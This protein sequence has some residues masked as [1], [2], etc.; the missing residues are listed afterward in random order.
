M[1][2]SD[3]VTTNLVVEAAP[4]RS[5]RQARRVRNTGDALRLAGLRHELHPHDAVAFIYPTRE[6]F[7]ASA[8]RDRRKHGNDV[9]GPYDTAQGLLGIVD[10]R[11]QM[12][13]WQQELRSRHPDS[14][15]SGDGTTN[16]ALPDGCSRR[17]QC[18]R[19]IWDTSAQAG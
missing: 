11:R 10:I 12:R 16:P 17:C 7:D 15:A 1:T 9:H 3:A 4:L 19:E 5:D 13:E 6:Y 8:D 2:E 14:P 18:H